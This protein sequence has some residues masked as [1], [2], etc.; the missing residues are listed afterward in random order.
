MQFTFAPH[1]EAVCTS[2]LPSP[3]LRISGVG[4]FSMLP[5]AYTGLLMYVSYGIL[6]VRFYREAYDRTRTRRTVHPHAKAV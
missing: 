2:S 3:E 4:E 5:V 6:F 1:E